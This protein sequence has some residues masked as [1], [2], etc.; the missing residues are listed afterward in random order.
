MLR[1]RFGRADQSNAMTPAT[2]GPAIDVPDNDVNAVSLLRVAERTLTPGA[3]MFG[4]S[5]A[6][7]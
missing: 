3:E 1:A 2:C 7:L 4:L 5:S 6:G